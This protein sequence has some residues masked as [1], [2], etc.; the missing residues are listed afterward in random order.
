L[1]FYCS[2][3]CLQNMGTWPPFEWGLWGSR[4]N[5]VSSSL[6]WARSGST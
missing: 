5:Q 1:L 2:G 6:S 4:S 3:L